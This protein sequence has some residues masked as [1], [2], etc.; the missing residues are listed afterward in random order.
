MPNMDGGDV[1]TKLRDD[2]DTKGIPII[3]LTSMVTGEEV[4]KKDGVIAG[5]RFVAKPADMKDLLV[6]IDQA[7]EAGSAK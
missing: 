4:K 3:F 2:P 7:I 5:D 1:A 6:Q